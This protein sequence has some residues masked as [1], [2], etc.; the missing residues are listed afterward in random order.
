MNFIPAVIESI[1]KAQRQKSVIRIPIR[2]P[3]DAEIE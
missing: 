2:F 1:N 3:N